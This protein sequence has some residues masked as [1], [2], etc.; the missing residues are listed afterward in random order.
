M[1]EALV[2]GLLIEAALL[3]AQAGVRWLRDQGPALI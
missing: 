1:I 3:L 2:V